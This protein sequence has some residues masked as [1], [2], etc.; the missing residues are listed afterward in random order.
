MTTNILVAGATGR[1]GRIIIKLLLKQGISPH[2]LVRDVST[3]QEL[4]GAKVVYHHGDIRDIGTILS[5]MTGIQ[6]VISAIG[7]QTPV[8]KNCPKRVDYEG[9]ANLVHAAV[10]HEVQRFILLSSIAVTHTNHPMNKFGGIL[11]WK[12]QGEN[13]LRSSGLDYAIIRPGCLTDTQ[14]NHRQ[15]LFDQGDNILGTISRTNVAEICLYALQYPQEM[16][17]TFEVIE[18]GRKGHPDWT[19]LFSA[20]SQD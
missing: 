6:T 8:G 13:V 17:V 11:Q 10:A 4:L 19:T 2:V 20:L 5:S 12:L 3:A 9:T 14:G 7:T 15:L 1:T 18:S 16:R